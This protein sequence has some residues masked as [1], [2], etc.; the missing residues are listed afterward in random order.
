MIRTKEILS[1]VRMLQEENLDVRTVTMGINIIDC[2]GPDMDAVCEAVYAKICRKAANLVRVCDEMTTRYGI[3]VVNKRLA[4]S[5]ASQLL[6]GHDA[7]DALALAMALDRAAADVKVDLLG[8][9]TA[10]VHKGMTPAERTMIE[11]LPIVLRDTKRVCASINIG[12]TKAGM[13]VDAIL[14]VGKT[15]LQIA[16]AT[17]DT[18]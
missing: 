18:Q 4:I 14:L 6:G 11:A 8:G 10:L 16:H 17:A 9:F 2:A 5:P 7:N 1:T 12:T 15:I 13:N 3:P